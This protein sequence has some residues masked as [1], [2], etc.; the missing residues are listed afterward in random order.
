MYFVFMINRIVAG[1]ANKV[2][3]PQDTA[4]DFDLFFLICIAK[5]FPFARQEWVV[6]E[7]VHSGHT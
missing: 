1:H 7:A 6:C 3:P 4:S 5:Y 2:F